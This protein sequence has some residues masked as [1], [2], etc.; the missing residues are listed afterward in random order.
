MSS[1]Q[2]FTNPVVLLIKILR[3]K[4]V[5]ECT[6]LSRSTIYDLINPN[7]DRHDP[8]FPKQ[9]KLST[10]SVGWVDTE[11]QAWLQAKIDSRDL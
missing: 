2:A 5:I 9:V 4:Q 11:I 8:T 3:L 6:G 7:S 10:N 1:Q